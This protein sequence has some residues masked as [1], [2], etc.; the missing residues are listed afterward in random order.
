MFDP[1]RIKSRYGVMICRRCLN[2][3]YKIH[4]VPED[5]IYEYRHI[6]PR[7]E[8]VH[9]IVSDLRFSGKRKMLWK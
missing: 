3:K 2:E 7:C 1:K 5:C 9:N 6:C 4:L 8:E